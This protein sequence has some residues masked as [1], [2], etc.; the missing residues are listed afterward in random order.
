[1]LGNWFLRG[2]SIALFIFG[3]KGADF[4]VAAEVV[5]HQTSEIAG[6][7]QHL[8]A[9]LDCP[10]SPDVPRVQT[11]RDVA[12]YVVALEAAGAACRQALA[13]NHTRSS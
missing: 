11:Q 9:L 2:F 7:R 10:V 4:G 8:A 5:H 6:L 13:E 3:F 12:R 1:M